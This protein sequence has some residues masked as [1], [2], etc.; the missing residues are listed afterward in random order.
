MST[1]QP[2]IGDDQIWSWEACVAAH[3]RRTHP[4]F[5][6]KGQGEVDVAYVR[7]DRFWPVQVKWT[8]QLRPKA[9]KQIARYPNGEIWSRS[10]EPGEVNGVR[11][12]P[13]P[14]ELLRF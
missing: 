1:A 6:I 8:N 4:T 2:P 11:S 7:D 9:L 14:I 12:L 3:C 10:R 5:Y 13:L